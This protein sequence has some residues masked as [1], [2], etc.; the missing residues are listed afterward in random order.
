MTLYVN[1][2][3]NNLWYDVKFAAC[4]LHGENAD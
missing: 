3:S 4:G 1:D 2:D